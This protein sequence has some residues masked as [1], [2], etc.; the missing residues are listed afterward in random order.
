MFIFISLCYICREDKYVHQCEH[1]N[2]PFN[3][4]TYYNPNACYS[5]DSDHMYEDSL[6]FYNPTLL[7]DDIEETI[8]M[9]II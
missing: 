4:A 7:D 9:K 1:Q 6:H 3:G 8:E 2:C 5:D